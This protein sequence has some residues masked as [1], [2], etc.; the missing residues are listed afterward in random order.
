MSKATEGPEKSKTYDA[1]PGATEEK[2]AVAA[3]EEAA[4]DDE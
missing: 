4:V 3:N 1:R 2:H